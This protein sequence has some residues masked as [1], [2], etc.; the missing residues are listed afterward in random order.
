MV[1]GGG[2]YVLGQRANVAGNHQQKSAFMQCCFFRWS[3]GL[4]FC[5]M[6]KGIKMCIYNVSFH[7]FI[8]FFFFHCTNPTTY[9]LNI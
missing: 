6:R 8:Y 9:V 4:G 2:D 7:Y 3:S 5:T 1:C